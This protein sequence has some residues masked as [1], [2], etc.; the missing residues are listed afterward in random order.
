VKISL[1]TFCTAHVDQ[2]HLMNSVAIG[3]VTLLFFTIIKWTQNSELWNIK[4]ISAVLY[5]SQL[6]SH[7][8]AAN[9]EIR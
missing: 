8:S 1:N 9:L 5:Q 6:M 3:D 4:E 7:N 2:L